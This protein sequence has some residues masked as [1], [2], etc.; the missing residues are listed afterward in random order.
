MS[1][2]KINELQAETTLADGDLIPFWK[3]SENK[4]CYIT[5]ANFAQ[6]INV[7]IMTDGAIIFD[8][9][10]YHRYKM[11]LQGIWQLF[12]TIGPTLP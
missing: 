10:N 5:A 2:K 3:T 9:A 8:G 12:E 7:K 4:T 1:K 11:D 6:A